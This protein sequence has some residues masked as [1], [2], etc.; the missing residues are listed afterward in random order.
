MRER[1]IARAEAVEIAKDR[2][3]VL[4]GVATFDADQN[5]GLAV[6]FR[7]PDSGGVAAERQHIRKAL[8]LGVNELDQA[9]GKAGGTAA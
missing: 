9:V 6:V 8:H 5:R 3:R 2:Q 4:D 1:Q 7:P